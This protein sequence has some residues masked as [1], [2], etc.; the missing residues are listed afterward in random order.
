M[1]R[2]AVYWLLAVP[3]MSS[4]LTS[5]AFTANVLTANAQASFAPVSTAPFTSA[6]WDVTG[7]EPVRGLTVG[8]IESTLHPHKGYG[9]DSSAEAFATVRRLGGNWV[10][11][12]PFGRI[13]DL[14]PTGIDLSFEAPSAENRKAIARAV[15]QAH[16]QGLKVMLVPHLWVEAGGWRGEIEFE[17][18]EAWA[19]WAAAYRAF[20]L[21][22]AR[23]AEQADVDLLSVGVELRSW[24]TTEHAA[25]FQ[26]FI[27]EVR[28]V[29]SGPLTYAANWDDAAHTVLWGELDVIGINAFFPLASKPGAGL[30]EL[31]AGGA[32]LKPELAGL[33]QAWNKPILFTEIGY[34]NRPDPAL[35]P[36]EWPEDLGTV[37][38]APAAQAAAYQALL[39]TFLDEPWFMG[40][41]VWRMYADPF[42]TS[43]EPAWGFSPLHQPAELVLRDAFSTRW[44]TRSSAR[45]SRAAEWIGNY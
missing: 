36:W 4:A 2:N 8:P 45:Y 25:S 19:N 29:Y 40:F 11:L 31:L 37:Q 5:G 44:G 22:W 35:R 15:A 12:T 23:V 43:Q 16:A 38:P 28:N 18:A 6:S 1:H 39:A 27:P 24:V 17:S 3:L 14:S 10:S 30:S 21:H 32:L 7:L 42:D 33:A 26:E 9:T 13:W 20:L 41:F 34:T